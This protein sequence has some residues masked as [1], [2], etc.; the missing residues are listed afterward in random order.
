MAVPSVSVP[1]PVLRDR[2]GKVM[3]WLTQFGM[4]LL[5]LG[6]R[7]LRRIRPIARV[8]KIYLVT[9][10]EDVRR[11]FETDAVFGAPYLPK[12]DLIMDHQRFILGMADSPDYRTDLAAL[13]R[14]VR[15]DDLPRLAADVSRR[16]TDIVQRS[17]GWLDVVSELTRPIAFD[18]LADYLGVPQP[19]Q[20]NL[21]QWGTRLFEYVFVA[22]DA[23]LK[24][25]AE[26]IAPVIRAHVQQAIDRRRATP[27]DR[28]D[29]LARCLALQAAGEPGYAD[30][31]IRT[32]LVGLIVGGPP[33]PPMVLPQAMEQLLRR[34]AALANA[35]AAAR[36]DDDD[37][38]WAILM[39]AMRFDPLAPW[40]PRVATTDYELGTG[41]SH[42]RTIP[43]GARIM[44]CILSAMHDPRQVPDPGRFTPG[45]PANAYI[46]F[47]LGLHECFGRHIN[48]AT[49]HLMLKPLLARPNLRRAKGSMGTL[50]RKGILASSLIVEFD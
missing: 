9:R 11:V 46:H 35:Q 8:G 4:G 40:L 2:G 22:D 31:A 23:P 26:Q 20:G 19:E 5:P 30:A 10:A 24:A 50:R 44:A 12:L 42:A 37:A 15:R 45:R 47:G 29:V 6:F 25:E 17:N 49:L 34:P 28:D 41:T 33:Q 16:A 18:F 7:L 21:H 1:L 32:A 38:L 48:R 27:I 39:E 36:A 3:Q 14:V 43:A 13:Q